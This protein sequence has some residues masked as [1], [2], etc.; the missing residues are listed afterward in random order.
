MDTNHLMNTKRVDMAR[1]LLETFVGDSQES[2]TTSGR[3]SGFFGTES[4]VLDSPAPRGPSVSGVR[5]A[6]PRGVTPLAGRSPA[7]HELSASAVH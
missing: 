4:S 2:P 3:S 6:P 1:P 7:S 5:T